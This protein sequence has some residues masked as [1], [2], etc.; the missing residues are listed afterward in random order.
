M[1]LWMLHCH[2]LCES[3]LT[4]TDPLVSSLIDVNIDVDIKKL[5]RLA[6]TVSRL[7]CIREVPSSNLGKDTDYTDK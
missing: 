6:Q 5:S 2:P 1:Q 3:A 4:Q 7:T